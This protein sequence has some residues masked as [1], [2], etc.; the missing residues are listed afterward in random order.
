MGGLQLAVIGSFDI[1]NPR[2]YS[3][4]GYYPIDVDM[5]LSFVIALRRLRR[6]KGLTQSQ[7]AKRLNISQQAYAKLETPFKANPSLSTL[8]KISNALEVEVK[9]DLVA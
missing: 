5:N 6:E 9:L 2:K 7:I 8:K 3:S 1:P 4:K